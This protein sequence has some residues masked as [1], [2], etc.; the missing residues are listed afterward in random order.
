MIKEIINRW[1]RNKHHLE[2]YIR[3][4]PQSSYDSYEDLV[5]ILIKD[6]LNH[7]LEEQEWSF[8]TNFNVID[9][10][11]WQG[12]QIFLLHKGI[13]QPDIDSY[14]LFDN[15]YGSCSGCDTL[16]SISGYDDGLPS[17]S[18]VRKYMYLLLSMVQR[19]RC[20]DDLYRQEEYEQDSN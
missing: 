5:L 7:N 9:H 17:E 18:Q 19:I 20:L 13:Y 2:E 10:G 15:Y 12:T 3:T 4:T 14:Y 8:S 16:L 6:C 1:E 11:D